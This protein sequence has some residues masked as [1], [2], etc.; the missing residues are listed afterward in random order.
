MVDEGR[1]GDM[2]HSDMLSKSTNHKP[3]HFE[4]P[5]TFPRCGV[6]WQRPDSDATLK[7]MLG[8]AMHLPSAGIVL[9]VALGSVQPHRNLFV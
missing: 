9:M 3:R 2:V 4:L 1:R 8:N 5:D 7:R 6:H